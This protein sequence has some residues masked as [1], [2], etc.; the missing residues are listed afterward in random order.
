MRDT[1]ARSSPR[2]GLGSTSRKGATWERG[3]RRP[4]ARWRE[5]VGPK[6]PGR[7]HSPRASRPATCPPPTFSSALTKDGALCA[8]APGRHAPPC[9]TPSARACAEW[10]WPPLPLGRKPWAAGH[11][12]ARSP[13]VSSAAGPAVGLRRP[14]SR[15]LPWAPRPPAMPAAAAPIISSVQKL[16]LYETR[17]VSRRLGRAGGRGRRRAPASQ[18]LIVTCAS[19]DEIFGSLYLKGKKNELFKDSLLV[20]IALIRFSNAS[21]ILN[22]LLHQMAM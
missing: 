13:A 17:A 4:E 7:A 16:V 6:H 18:A 20:W 21:Y 22:C 1:G 15:A 5:A 19:I 14:L 11:R 9:G 12:V 10:G 3:A 8:Q 2:P